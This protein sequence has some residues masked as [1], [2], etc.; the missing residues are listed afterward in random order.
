MEVKFDIHGITSLEYWR[1]LDDWSFEVQQSSTIKSHLWVF[2]ASLGDAH[3]PDLLWAEDPE[4]DPLHHLHRSL[5]VAGDDGRHRGRLV[6]NF[7]KE[8]A[9]LEA[10]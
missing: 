2:D 4:L 3:P 7:L 10:L 5:G 1:Q 6:L 9:R 8:T